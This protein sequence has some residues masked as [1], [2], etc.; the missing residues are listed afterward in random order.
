MPSRS[1]SIVAPVSGEVVSALTDLVVSVDVNNAGPSDTY[2]VVNCSHS[3]GL[4]VGYNGLVPANS[5]KSIEVSIPGAHIGSFTGVLVEARLQDFSTW[6]TA[7]YAASAVDEITIS[8]G[9]VPIGV[10]PPVG[11]GPFAR[12]RIEDG[13][14]MNKENTGLQYAHKYVAAAAGGF[15]LTGTVAD[16]FK[17]GSVRAAVYGLLGKHGLVLTHVE[18]NVPINMAAKTWEYT[19]PKAVLELVAQPRLV[20]FSLRD[21][22]G[23]YRGSASA[24]LKKK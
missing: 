11:G 20:V 12:Y 13:M 8:G 6:N 22:A 4:H 1:L 5:T 17:D 9:A 2:V 21:K 24:S 14:V 10:D 16:A 23:E 18:P 7:Y 19:V 15:K 3:S